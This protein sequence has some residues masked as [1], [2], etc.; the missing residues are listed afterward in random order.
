MAGF[1]WGLALGFTLAVVVIGSLTTLAS[2]PKEALRVTAGTVRG[3]AF[4]GQSL[5]TPLLVDTKVGGALAQFDLVSI[6]DGLEATLI[7]EG[8]TRTLRVK[9]KFAGVYSGF[10]IRLGI[11]DPLGI[12]ERTE[13][14]ETK[15]SFEFIPT[16]LLAEREPL[17]VSAAMLGDYPAGRRGLG[18]EF[19]SAEPYSPT[20]NSRD[21]MWK[22]QA[23]A[24]GDSLMVRVGEA[25]IPERLTACLIE[26]QG[27][28]KRRS[29]A[30]MDLAS[31]AIARVGLPVISSGTTFRLLHVLGDKT[32][33]REARD[34]SGLADM[35][36]WL[37]G[38]DEA[39]E[40]SEERPA[41]ADIIV[42]AMAE[43]EAP[44]I[45]RLVLSKSS[46][47]LGWDRRGATLS[48]GI[49]FFSGREDVSGLVARVLGR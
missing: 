35:I 2:F 48:S 29:P 5:S 9:S 14:H 30:W 32:S 4:K 8:G 11:L 37:W 34:A 7:G 24:P 31:E 46:V 26:R 49:V 43:T 38:S 44:E 13:V 47:L 25:N 3:K 17:R 39:R 33:S 28:P 19:Y 36:A 1:G 45:M 41:G 10:K 22:R 15:L 42:T 21:I 27:V 6:P 23:K 18:Q 12:F 16:Y 20:S 40:P